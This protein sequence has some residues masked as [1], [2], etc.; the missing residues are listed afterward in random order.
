VQTRTFY[1]VT[2]KEL[3]LRLRIRRLF[4]FDCAWKSPE[5]ERGDDDDGTGKPPGQSLS[6][7]GGT[8]IQHSPAIGAV[9]N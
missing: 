1:L 4:Y 7:H 9:G 2:D 8:P 3:N 6:K 5:C